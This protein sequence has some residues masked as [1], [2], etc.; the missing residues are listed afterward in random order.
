MILF[1]PAKINLGLNILRKREDGFHEI[2][3]GMIAIPL[4]DAL[5]ILPAD[6]FSFQQ[7]GIIIDSDPEDNLCVKAYRLLESNYG[8]SPVNIQ[9]VKRIPMGAGLGGGSADAS[10]V[11]RGLSD[12]FNLAISDDRLRELAAQLGS[13]CAFFISDQPQIA[14]GRGELLEPAD[15]DLSGYWIKLINPGIHISTAEAYAN[16]QFSLSEE[17]LHA[18]L[19]RPMDEWKHS[20]ENGFEASIFPMHPELAE[21]KA[22]LYDE[23]AIYAS[24]SGSGSTL[25]GIFKSRPEKMHPTY[26]EH[27][28][29]W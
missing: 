16:V 26:F 11:L 8:I 13:D 27:I 12:L 24:M 28:A 9:L 14:K 23:G 15:V 6:S 18:L 4:F 29:Q 17:P 21:I 20:V 7:F 2:E 1:P 5:E 25:F 3:S 19:K 22:K 10:Y